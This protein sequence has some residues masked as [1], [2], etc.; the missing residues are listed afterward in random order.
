MNS[1][2]FSV[3]Y[4][5]HYKLDVTYLS[6]LTS[7]HSLC[8][9]PTFMCA[10]Y[11]TNYSSYSLFCKNILFHA[12]KSSVRYSGFCLKCLPPSL[13]ASTIFS[14]KVFLYSTYNCSFLLL[15]FI[16]SWNYWAYHIAFSLQVCVIPYLDSDLL[17]GRHN[18]F[19][20]IFV[21]LVPN[22]CDNSVHACQELKLM[23]SIVLIGL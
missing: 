14:V 12:S 8:P 17:R 11:S 15:C 7:H 4:K 10:V 2:I 22:T 5:I 18:T 16:S 6:S 23:Q 3:M 9:L 19:V 1:Q 13:P 21:F 20:F